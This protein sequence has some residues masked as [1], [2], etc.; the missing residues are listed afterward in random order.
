MAMVIVMKQHVTQSNSVA[1]K[2]VFNS[3][4]QYQALATQT[5]LVCIVGFGLFR[6]VG[7]NTVL[8]L[9]TEIFHLLSQDAK[10]SLVLEAFQ[11]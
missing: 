2:S 7:E 1:L 5:T 10:D 4:G 8:L 11:M 6:K 9:S 3:F